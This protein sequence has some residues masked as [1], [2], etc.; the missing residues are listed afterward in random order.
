MFRDLCRDDAPSWQEVL[1]A[2]AARCAAH[3][4][5]TAVFDFTVDGFIRYARLT[6][7]AEAAKLLDSLV[8]PLP[9]E[10]VRD[11]FRAHTDR[12]HLQRLAPERR[13]AV[14]EILKQLSTPA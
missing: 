3:P 10:T 5:E 2:L 4:K 1:P 11:A 6:S 12:E 7:P 13:T 14:L 8:D 9:F